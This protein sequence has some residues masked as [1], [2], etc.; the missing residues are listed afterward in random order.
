MNLDPREIAR[1][2]SKLPAEELA[3]FFASLGNELSLESP[4]FAPPEE[5]EQE[6]YSSDSEFCAVLLDTVQIRLAELAKIVSEI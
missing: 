4:A 6:G 1:F 2:V 3:D 5:E